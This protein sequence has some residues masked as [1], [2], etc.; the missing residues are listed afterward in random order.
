MTDATTY[1]L[2]LA[3][4]KPAQRVLNFDPLAVFEASS[5][6]TIEAMTAKRT[7]LDS[8]LDQVDAKVT[9]RLKAQALAEAQR[10]ARKAK[11]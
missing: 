9:R 5:W 7:L 2:R 3:S 1:M 6:A 11:P 10:R 8:Y 4:A